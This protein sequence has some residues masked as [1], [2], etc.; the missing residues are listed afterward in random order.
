MWS[1]VLAPGLPHIQQMS[2]A[3]KIACR[4]RFHC[5][6]PR[7]LRSRSDMVRQ[8]LPMTIYSRSP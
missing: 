4:T 3:D 7:P 6:V 5:E 2:E 1:T 8:G